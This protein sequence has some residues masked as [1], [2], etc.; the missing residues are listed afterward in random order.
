MEMVLKDLKTAIVG[1][2]ILHYPSLQ[3]TMDLVKKLA[4]S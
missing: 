4:N 3:S 2:T 1:H